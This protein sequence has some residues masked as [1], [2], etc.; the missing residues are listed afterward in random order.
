MLRDTPI[1]A[2]TF[3]TC[4]RGLIIQV[5]RNFHPKPCPNADSGGMDFFVVFV[6]ANAA[7]RRL[8]SCEDLGN[9]LFSCFSG[10][11]FHLVLPFFA[12]VVVADCSGA[13]RLHHAQGMLLSMQ[14]V[15]V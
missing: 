9:G 11:K 6:Q 5:A 14:W 15:E 3:L 12:N 2:S 8:R 7:I 13:P 10:F 1:S 4:E